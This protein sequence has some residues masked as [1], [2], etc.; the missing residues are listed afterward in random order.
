MI[1]KTPTPQTQTLPCSGAAILSLSDSLTPTGGKGYLLTTTRPTFG[2]L[3]L[4][5]R[6]NKNHYNDR[7]AEVSMFSCIN[8]RSAED[9]GAVKPMDEDKVTQEAYDALARD[10]TQSMVCLDIFMCPLPTSSTT[11][12]Q[13]PPSPGSPPRRSDPLRCP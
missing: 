1:S 7:E 12:P 13:P 9:L 5:G 6:E 2:S 3:T 4:R 10:L 11:P 8:E